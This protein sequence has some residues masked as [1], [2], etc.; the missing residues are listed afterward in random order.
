[1]VSAKE[2]E[3]GIDEFKSKS[4]VDMT[5]LLRKRNDPTDRI[6]VFFP[7]EA[8]VGVQP[9]RQYCERMAAEAVTRAIIVVQE[10]ITPFARQGLAEL[11]HRFF[12]EQ[13][14]ESELLV[15]ITEHE[16]VPRHVPLT[17]HEKSQ[18]L[19]RYKCKATQLPRIQVTDPIARYYGLARGTVV[20]IIRKSETAGRYITYR[21]VV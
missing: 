11:S 17:P 3:S 10:G 4:R 12:I 9:I 18:L 5:R 8:K 6:F 1:M 19:A 15:N 13:F 21:L 2:L 7:D 14:L 16:L 20:K